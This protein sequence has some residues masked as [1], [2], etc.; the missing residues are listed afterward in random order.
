M[1]PKKKAAPKKA[2]V[3]LS[4]YTFCL[5]GKFDNTRESYTKLIQAAG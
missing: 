3:D 4:T 2:E 5:S 1:P